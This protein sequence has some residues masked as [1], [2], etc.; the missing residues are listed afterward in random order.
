[1]TLRL[2]GDCHIA[3]PREAVWATL[4]DA[5]ALRALIPHCD[6]LD[7]TSPSTL[8][9]VVRGHVGPIRVRLAGTLTLSQRVPPESYLLTGAGEGGLAGM[10]RGAVLVRLFEEGG[11]TRLNYAAE[12]RF[13][14]RLAGFGQRLLAKAASRFAEKFLAA[15]AAA[16]GKR[17]E[18]A[19]R[20]SKG[21]SA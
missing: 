9:V 5:D 20:S 14:G 12:A 13:G 4:N 21:K 15:F 17:V 7:W 1:M 16:V 8:S 11:G 6:E 19:V 2:L 3:A 18:A 10:A